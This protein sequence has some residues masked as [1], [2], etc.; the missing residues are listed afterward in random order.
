MDQMENKNPIVVYS[1]Y[2]KFPTIAEIER[3]HITTV[4]LNTQGNK[5]EAATILG[6]SL[7]TLY[8]KLHEYAKQDAAA[9]A[10]AP[11]E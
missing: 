5:R 8:N 7:K 2:D 6:I 11:T 9:Q 3:Q 10:P 1:F 4:L